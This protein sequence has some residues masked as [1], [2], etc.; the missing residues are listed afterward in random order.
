MRD[1][2]F[3]M[4]DER[5]PLHR[6]SYYGAIFDHMVTADDADPEVLAIAMIETGKDRRRFASAVLSFPIDIIEN[7]GKKRLIV[8]ICH[9]MKKR[10]QD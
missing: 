3:G 8:P 7:A 10:M 4:G 1:E 9:Q 2:Y 6:I 5:R